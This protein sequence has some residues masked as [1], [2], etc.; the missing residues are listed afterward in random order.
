MQKGFNMSI[1][2][3][4]V[5]V[6]IL[7]V[8]LFAGC[9]QQASSPVLNNAKTE[10]FKLAQVHG[11]IECHRTNGAVI[12]PSWM[13][14]AERYKDSPTEDARALLIERVKKGSKGNWYTWKGGD[15]M[16]PLEKR[17]SSEAIEKLVDYILILRESDFSSKF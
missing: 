12:G 7:L 15:G 8:G 14:I 16:A 3:S 4:S 9:E 5:L 6:V 13:D 10:L 2:Y 1:K 17:V 11:C